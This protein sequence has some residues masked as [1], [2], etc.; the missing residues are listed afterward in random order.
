MNHTL[1]KYVFKVKTEC[2]RMGFQL[3][4]T[5]TYK[6]TVVLLSNPKSKSI[7][8]AFYEADIFGDAHIKTYLI[9]RNKYEWASAEGF[10]LDE[11]IQLIDERIFIEINPNKVSGYLL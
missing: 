4:V 9:N 10:T 3:K 5:E 2:L 1:K 11:M 8:M 6:D 7:T